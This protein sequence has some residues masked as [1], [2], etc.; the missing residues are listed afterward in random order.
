MRGERVARALTLA[1]LAFVVVLVLLALPSFADPVFV[2]I[3]R[4][5]EPVTV[6]MSWPVGQA[7]EADIPTQNTRELTLPDE[8]EVIFTVRYASGRHHASEPMYF[9]RGATIVVD[10][11]DEGPTFRHDTGMR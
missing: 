11:G 3:N 4:A 1:A 10:I 8:G 7:V 9:T 2:L 5:S 6:E